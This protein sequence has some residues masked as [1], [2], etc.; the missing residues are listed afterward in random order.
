MIRYCVAAFRSAAP[1]FRVTG[2]GNL[3]QTKAR[4]VADYGA[5]TALA[6]QTMADSNAGWLALNCESNLSAAAR[7]ISGHDQIRIAVKLRS[8]TLIILSPYRGG[9]PPKFPLD[10][11]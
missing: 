10:I 8:S 1:G 5:G 3:L 4:L 9:V 7:G 6:F 11:R 2:K